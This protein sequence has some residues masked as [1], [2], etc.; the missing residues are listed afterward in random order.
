MRNPMR[1]AGAFLAVT[2]LSAC[3]DSGGPTPPDP[4]ATVVSITVSPS[5]IELIA[6]ATVQFSAQLRDGQGNILT[7]RSVAWSSADPGVAQVGSNG[8]V[9]G[10]G[11][12]T[13]SIAASSASVTGTASV[14]VGS[15]AVEFSPDSAVLLIADTVRVTVELD[16]EGL[17]SSASAIL[18]Q[19]TDPSIVTIDENGLVE[20][21]GLGTV[22]IGAEAVF[23]SFTVEG[24]ADL[25]VVEAEQP[26]EPLLVT[27]EAAVIASQLA[28]APDL[29]EAYESLIEAYQEIY[30]TLTSE[31]AAEQVGLVDAV[32]LGD[33]SDV[34][35]DDLHARLSGMVFGDAAEPAA[36]GSSG[37][38]LASPFVDTRIVFI[39]GVNNSPLEAASGV[40]ALET[41]L[42]YLAPMGWIP[43][44]Y[45][46]GAE[47]NYGVSAVYNP[48][49][50]Q[51]GNRNALWCFSNPTS[52][53]Q[54]KVQA[55]TCRT[56]F[57]DVVEA[58]GQVLGIYGVFPAQ[59]EPAAAKFAAEINLHLQNGA[60][61]LVVPHSQGNLMA[62]EALKLV[63]QSR[64]CV[65]I[66]SIASPLSDGWPS[67]MSR[68]AFIAEGDEVKDFLLHLPFPQDDPRIT[69][70]YHSKLLELDAEVLT[71]SALTSGL[72]RFSNDVEIHGVQHYLFPVKDEPGDIAMENLVAVDDQVALNCSG[73]IEVELR[74]TGAPA[75]T[76]A[77]VVLDNGPKFSTPPGA[78]TL[79][80]IERVRLGA[81]SLTLTPPEVP[82]LTCMVMDPATVEVDVQAGTAMQRT[83]FL[84]ECAE[85]SVT[86]DSPISFDHVFGVTECSQ[87]IGSPLT[88]TNLTDV[89]MSWVAS[90][91]G[92][93]LSHIDADPRK[94]DLQPGE[95]VEVDLTYSCD[96]HDMSFETTEEFSYTTGPGGV[97]GEVEIPIS[98]TID[99]TPGTLTVTTV[100]TGDDL[101]DRYDVEDVEDGVVIGA[102]GPNETKSFLDVRP[103]RY[104]I[105]MRPIREGVEVGNCTFADSFVR[106]IVLPA[107]G[108]A[109]ASF[110]V[111]CV[112]S[113]DFVYVVNRDSKDVSVIDLV[114][115]TVTATV[116]VGNGPIGVAI[117]PDGAFAYVTNTSSD[118]VSV[119]RLSD[120]AV[121][122]TVA[123]G[124]GPIGIA[125]TPD[126]AFAYVANE[127]ADNVSVIDLATNTVTATIAVGNHPSGIAIRPDG[128]FAY[129]TNETSDNV[130]VINLATNT[131]TATI[132]VG[133]DPKGIAIRPDGAFAYV[134]NTFSDDVSVIDLATNT[135][136]ATIAVGEDP[137][138]IAITPGGG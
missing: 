106:D 14:R 18:W 66:F 112:P 5:N 60:Q 107:D 13:V 8:L 10:V 85:F 119:I 3:G 22:S 121:I 2:L 102:I 39:N 99:D 38:T 70:V 30:A 63:G 56:L 87:S 97:Q 7:G 98:A 35:R 91:Q 45:G 78:L 21:V 128:A 124:D 110:A 134:T 138:G 67:D 73:V 25:I 61:V 88:V 42:D 100:T 41:M 116:G 113:T 24:S 84:V 136:T 95:S 44:R 80:S 34:A 50:N 71:A 133:R 74:M 96:Y 15:V 52:W 137:N 48:T 83:S 72:K 47:P 77:E 59:A 109:S 130:S 76:Q 40:A 19:S 12:G 36:L 117:T 111:E 82:G 11:S 92:P 108:T 9:T 120:N 53:L 23:P 26:P 1:L 29:R 75:G 93:G 79:T 31:E 123:V 89:P 104:K 115:N 90:E 6:G 132:A 114:T 81:H 65:G 101:L 131:V 118:D 86:P 46:T 103:G 51:A 58:A 43:L 55:L 135:V 64:E 17:L 125:I 62:Q 27:Q 32:G 16:V 126:G 4:V 94:G 54:Q 127:G 69:P 49:F 105:R 20:A 33:L 129:V 57:A 28:T 122:A 37:R 68:R